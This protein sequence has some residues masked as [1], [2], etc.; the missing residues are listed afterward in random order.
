MGMTETAGLSSGVLINQTNHV[1]VPRGVEIG[2][3]E[4]QLPCP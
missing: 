2:A 3:L 1:H 4:A